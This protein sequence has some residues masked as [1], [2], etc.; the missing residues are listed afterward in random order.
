MKKTIVCMLLAALLCAM[1]VLAQASQL[2]NIYIDKDAMMKHDVS[3]A[4]IRIRPEG[5]VSVTRHSLWPWDETEVKW[6][7][8]VEIENTSK[9]K[10]V[11]DENWLVACKADREEI[12]SADGAFE[13][14]DNVLDPGEKTVLFAGIESWQMP[15]DY[16]DVTDFEA[17]EGLEAFSGKIRRAKILRVRL[18]TRGNT[19]TRNWERADVQGKAWIEDGKIRFEMDNTTDGEI[20]FRT[21]GV[22]VSDADGRLMDVL[23]TSYSRGAKAMPGEQIAMEKALQPYVTEEMAAGAQ[24]EVF[25]YLMPEQMQ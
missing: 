20:A 3:A 2:L 9:E 19:S 16:H 21:L 4:D 7:L 10:I 12:A 23:I 15:T 24:F 11:I 6:S 14:T 13:M 1:T 18:E 5:M 8:F 25:G 17:V 22:L